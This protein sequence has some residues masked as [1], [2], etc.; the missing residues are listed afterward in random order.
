MKNLVISLKK[1]EEMIREAYKEGFIQGLLQ[2]LNGLKRV[3]L[4]KELK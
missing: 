4:L 2:E 1:A 3:G